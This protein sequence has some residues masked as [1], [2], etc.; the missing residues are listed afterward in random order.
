VG[1]F[2]KKKWAQIPREIYVSL[3]G[4]FSMVEGFTIRIRTV[5]I[6]SESGPEK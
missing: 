3:L 1:T 4:H 6:A 5:C 2:P